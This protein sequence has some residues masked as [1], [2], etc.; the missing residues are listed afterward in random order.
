M[1]SFTIRLS[2]CCYFTAI[3][4]VCLNSRIFLKDKFL[5]ENVVVMVSIMFFIF[6]CC[7]LKDY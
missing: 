5:A 7:L 1:T 3:K 4:K 6:I 2:V